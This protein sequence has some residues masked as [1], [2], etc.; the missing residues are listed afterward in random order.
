M[1]ASVDVNQR[2]VFW[3]LEDLI[4]ANAGIKERVAEVYVKSG[5]TFV[6]TA[7]RLSP[8]DT[9]ALKRSIHFTVA[10]RIPRMRIGSIK[11]VKN[12]K[13][14]KLATTYAPYVHDGTS[15]MAPRPFIWQAVMQHTTPQGNF[16][17]GLR[18][19]GV[20]NI[21]RSTGGLS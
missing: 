19:A 5:P 13:T 1:A 17:R 18:K 21:G 20:G 16:M 15:R 12:P 3:L 10:K 7:Q 6:R 8:E 4:D 14:G 9:G 11:R 2:A